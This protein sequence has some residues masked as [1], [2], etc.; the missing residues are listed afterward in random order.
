MNGYGEYVCVFERVC[1]CVCM[2]VEGG[3]GE[4]VSEALMRVIHALPMSERVG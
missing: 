4:C 2:C 1:V 3:Y